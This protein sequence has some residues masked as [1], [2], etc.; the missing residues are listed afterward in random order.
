MRIAIG[1]DHRGVDVGRALMDYLPGRDHEVDVLGPCLSCT[2]SL[3]AKFSALATRA[4]SEVPPPVSDTI[5]L[6]SVRSAA[7]WAFSTSTSPLR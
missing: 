2:R 5:A 3:S 4:E 7:C 6:S 1:M